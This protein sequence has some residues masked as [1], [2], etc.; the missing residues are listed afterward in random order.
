LVKGGE[1]A[2]WTEIITEEML[3]HRLWPRA[4]AVA[5]RLWSPRSVHDPDDMRR[6]LF[7]VLPEL[8]RAGLR[9]RLA[10]DA[11]IERL[12]PGN[13]LPVKTLV[14]VAA[15]V[16]NHAHNHSLRALL[17]FKRA[18]PQSFDQLADIASP[19]NE[20]S[21]ALA[22]DV[23]AYLAGDRGRLARLRRRLKTLRDNDA[24]FA[25]V[26]LGRPALEA[27]LPV[28]RDLKALAIF[29]LE[30][31]ADR[32]AHRSPSIEWRGR[33]SELLTRQ[34]RQRAASDTSFLALISNE[35]PPD[36][37]VIDIAPSIGVL[38]GAAE[39]P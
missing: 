25:A 8:R 13:P 37:L 24:A 22:A 4:A 27:A 17:Q 39:A 1:A 3:D 21:S 29:G 16:R 32:E 31:L 9:D 33:A 35:L 19:D 23:R 11:M 38:V 10:R 18:P 20:A 15:P 26:A 34:T 28:S 14:E 12:A 5:E 2:L 6:R 36:D 30:A 7:A